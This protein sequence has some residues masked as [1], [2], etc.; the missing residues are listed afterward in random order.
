MGIY[1]EL[2]MAR[3]FVILVLASAAFAAA[4]HT[5]DALIELG[6]GFT[7][8]VSSR[9]FEGEGKELK[10][11]DQ[12][13]SLDPG[14]SSNDPL[15]KVD[16]N[17][18]DDGNAGSAAK[19]SE[20]EA[21]ELSDLEAKLSSTDNKPQQDTAKHSG[22]K[23]EVMDI[24]ALEAKL[25]GIDATK[26][27]HTKSETKTHSHSA[28]AQEDTKS[29]R[30]GDQSKS[31]RHSVKAH[32]KHSQI[33]CAHADDEECNPEHCLCKTPKVAAPKV[34]APKVAVPKV[35]APKKQPESAELILK[36]LKLA[37]QRFTA[38]KSAKQFATKNSEEHKVDKVTDAKPTAAD[39]LSKLRSVS[40]RFKKVV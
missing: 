19:T 7:G 37:S 1:R 4:D 10:G 28:R 11:I 5:P 25:D 32:G 30:A 33:S 24:T 16:D 29:D 27:T 31:K 15:A 17:D 21:L 18:Y 22:H 9:N 3:V 14:V 39:I 40:K 20:V 13:L 23:H 36:K 35:A 34:A 2:D 26:P 8:V 6:T 12:A 38:S